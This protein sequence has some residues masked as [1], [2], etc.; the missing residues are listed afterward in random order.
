MSNETL[1]TIDYILQKKVNDYKIAEILIESQLDQ[2]SQN[3]K[4]SLYFS[5]LKD[6]QVECSKLIKEL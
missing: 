4:E 2:I 6:K 5:I 3:S 1:K